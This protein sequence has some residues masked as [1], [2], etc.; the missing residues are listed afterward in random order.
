MHTLSVPTQRRQNRRR[1]PSCQ[2]LP[3]TMALAK[4]YCCYLLTPRYLP[5]RGRVT[6]VGFTVDPARRLRQHNGEIKGGAMR[7]KRHRPWDMIAVAI[8]FPSKYAAL[9]FEYALQ[10][11]YRGRRVREE[12]SARFGGKRNARACGGRC[13]LK[14]KLLEMH[15][16]LSSCVP[17]S[18]FALTLRFSH[19]DHAAAALAVGCASLPAVMASEVGTLETIKRDHGSVGDASALLERDDSGCALCEAEHGFAG[20]DKVL[21]CPDCSAH[22]H[23]G[24]LGRELLR[25]E[26]PQSTS[27]VPSSGTCPV[28]AELILWAKL[29]RDGPVLL[30]EKCRVAGAGAAPAGAVRGMRG[31][32][33]PRGDVS[34]TAAARPDKI[35]DE[36]DDEAIDL[37]A[38]LSVLC[39]PPWRPPPPPPARADLD[40]ASEEEEE[41]E[42]EKDLEA[43]FI[44]L[45]LG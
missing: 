14:R 9:A 1:R 27:L 20:G 5:K 17:F 18:G 33:A 15:C 19:P 31:A 44:G 10:Y 13:S 12:C 26:G 16:I 2:R 38:P 3:P 30:A 43:C 36:F 37:T 24:C 25:Q 35:A 22:F 32:R 40:S 29:M 42:T 45:A 23:T 28:C 6:Y 21:V 39:I 11:P 4:L 34:P 8:G 41:E 7:T